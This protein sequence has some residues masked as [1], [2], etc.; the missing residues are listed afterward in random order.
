MV[1]MELQPV[2][3]Q[4]KM[5]ELHPQAQDGLPESESPAALRVDAPSLTPVQ[6]YTWQDKGTYVQ[7]QIR[8]AHHVAGEKAAS[9]ES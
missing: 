2:K 5:L 1:Q 7:L 6:H 4:L 3:P 9:S 8:A